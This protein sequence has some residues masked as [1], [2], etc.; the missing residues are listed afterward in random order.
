MLKS[1]RTT[2]LGVVALFTAATDTLIA[3]LDTDVTTVPNWSFVI[4]SVIA[5]LIGLFA[6]D[7]NETVIQPTTKK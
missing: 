5:F 4:M 2:A 1:W 7:A 3:W 6:K